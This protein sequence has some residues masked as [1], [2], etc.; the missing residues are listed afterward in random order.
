MIID[1]GTKEGKGGAI[2][3]VSSTTNERALL[4]FNTALIRSVDID[5]SPLRTKEASEQMNIVKAMAYS[6]GGK[7]T[8]AKM[9]MVEAMLSQKNTDIYPELRITTVPKK[10]FG[11]K[12]M[13]YA[14]HYKDLDDL[15]DDYKDLRP[16]IVSDED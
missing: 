4:N 8:Q 1:L 5:D 3:I 16:F 12:T 6:S 2:E 13:I 11:S 9:K 7:S 10:G 14:I 15:M